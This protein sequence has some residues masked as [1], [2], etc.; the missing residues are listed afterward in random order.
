MRAR[1]L[2]KPHEIVSF[3]MV[4]KINASHILV[5]KQSEALKILEELEKGTSFEELARKYSTCPSRKRGGSLGKFG[6]GQMVKEFEKAAFSLKKGEITKN[7]VK[8]NFGYHIIKIT[9]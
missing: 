2:I 5:E 3:D 4:S 8:T 6:R 7:P 1:S 9:G